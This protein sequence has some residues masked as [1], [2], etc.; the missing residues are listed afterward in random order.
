MK[1]D[2]KNK[3]KSLTSAKRLGEK[4]QNDD[5]NEIVQELMSQITKWRIEASSNYNDGWTR[6]HYQE[7]LDK[8][9]S[10]MD[11]AYS[12]LLP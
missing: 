4:V 10:S 11:K 1:D 9:K 2:K 3:S 7:K 8:L 6:Q 12:Q 5:G